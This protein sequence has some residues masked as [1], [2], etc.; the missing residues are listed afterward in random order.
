MHMAQHKKHCYTLMVLLLLLLMMPISLLAQECA[1]RSNL[2]QDFNR[3][4]IN[5]NGTVTDIES[6]LT[7]LRCVAG[8]RWDGKTCNGEAKLLNWSEAQQF[9]QQIQDDNGALSQWRLPKLNEL[10]GIVDIRCKAPRINLTLFP[11][12]SPDPFWTH[13]SS[14]DTSYAFILS[15]GKEG[16]GTVPKSEKHY[17]RLVSGRESERN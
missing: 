12:T 15:F 16:V 11:N 14:S 2:P 17:V 9:T 7:W 13:N 6:G 1:E 4:D 10:A 5:S 8:Q 3:F